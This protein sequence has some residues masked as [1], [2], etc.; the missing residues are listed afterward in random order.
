MLEKM[1]RS[2]FFKQKMNLGYYHVVLLTAKTSPE[3]PK[4]TADETQHMPNI[5]KNYSYEEVSC[6]I[7]TSCNGRRKLCVKFEYDA[8]KLNIVVY[9]YRNR[10]YLKDNEV[11]LKLIEHQPLLA[12]RVHLLN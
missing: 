1:E 6:L 4:P 7:W 2:F 9:R 5:E 11:D 12:K 8:D 3:K 10:L